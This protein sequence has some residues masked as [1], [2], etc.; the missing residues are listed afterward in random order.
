MYEDLNSY[1]EATIHIDAFNSLELKLYPF[2]PNPPR[3][4]DWAVPV[5]LINLVERVE[6]NWDITMARVCR[7][8]DGVRYVKKIARDVDVDDGL[9]REAIAHLLYVLRYGLDQ[10]SLTYLS[11]DIINVS[12]S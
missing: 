8:I 2:Y 3:V 10:E 11:L 4:D 1:S 7:A 5:A 12:C 9:C 6:S